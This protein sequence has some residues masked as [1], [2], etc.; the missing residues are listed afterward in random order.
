MVFTALAFVACKNDDNNTKPSLLGKWTYEKNVLY[1]GAKHEPLM[2]NQGETC[3]LLDSYL[4]E[5]D[6]K[7][8]VTVHDE[9]LNET[10]ISEAFISSYV[11]N[12]A[13]NTVQLNIDESVVFQLHNH[14]A[15]TVGFK[16]RIY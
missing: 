4:F 10:Y 5:N 1:D 7:L 14:T 3:Q 9:D 13:E 6:G 16:F 2:T 11:H 15:Q 12:Q 8:T